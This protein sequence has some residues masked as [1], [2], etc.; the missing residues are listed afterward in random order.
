MDTK[1]G[2]V[3][4]RLTAAAA[5]LRQD[6]KI[7]RGKPVFSDEKVK[8]FWETLEARD[9]IRIVRGKLPVTTIIPVGPLSGYL[10]R[11]RTDAALKANA[12]FFIMDR[13][14]CATVF[15]HIGTPLGLQVKDGVVLNP[16]LYDREAL[17]VKKDGSVSLEPSQPG[18]GGRKGK[19]AGDCGRPC[20]GGLRRPGGHSRLGLRTAAGGAL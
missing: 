2:T 20:G 1:Y 5:A 18:L 7:R 11:N 19:E 4:D 6:V 16:P 14:D 8:A 13:F 15:D 17:L 10:S 9:C 3:A 12:S